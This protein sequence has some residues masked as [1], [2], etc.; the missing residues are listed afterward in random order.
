MTIDLDVSPESD[1]HFEKAAKLAASNVG[2]LVFRLNYDGAFSPRFI[3][4]YVHALE[5]FEK[6]LYVL[7]P[8]TQGIILYEGS[9]LDDLSLYVDR[10]ISAL[11]EQVEGILHFTLPKSVAK[12]CLLVSPERYPWAVIKTTPVLGNPTSARGVLFPTEEKCSQHVLDQFDALFE[13][14]GDYRIV[15]EYNFTET[16]DGLDEVIIMPKTLS[17]LG[18]RKLK[19]FEAAGG[20]VGVEGFEPPTFWTQTRRASQAALYP[21]L[22]H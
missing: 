18:E 12:A 22:K 21:D 6:T 4:C 13:K 3:N 19:G 11:P 1:L 9:A 20:K 15:Y 16:W 2:P 14:L 10:L 7:F 8:K 5:Y 17:P